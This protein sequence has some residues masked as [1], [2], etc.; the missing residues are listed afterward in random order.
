MFSTLF[1][2][3][4][5]LSGPNFEAFHVYSS[6]QPEILI[7]VQLLYNKK[8]LETSSGLL[9]IWHIENV[10]YFEIWHI[11]KLYSN[12]KKFQSRPDERIIPVNPPRNFVPARLFF[13]QVQVARESLHFRLF[14]F[15]EFLHLVQS[16]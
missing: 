4:P 13:F 15:L 1:P 7:H 10:A 8:Q 9:K 3:S 12:K 2:I 11:P 16:I 6:T 14:Q 5:A